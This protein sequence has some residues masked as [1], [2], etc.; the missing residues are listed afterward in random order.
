M[1]GILSIVPDI[2]SNFGINIPSSFTLTPPTGTFTARSTFTT[3]QAKT[4]NYN[5]LAHLTEIYLDNSGSLDAN[6]GEK[7][8]IN[9]AGVLNLSIQASLTDWITQ[10]SLSFLYFPEDVEP[11]QYQSSGQA[12]S[13]IINGAAANSN[14]IKSYQF[15]GDGY[16]L[17]R[18]HMVPKSTDLTPGAQGIY[19]DQTD[20]KWSLSYAFSVYDIEDVVDVPNLPKNLPLKCL[21]IYFRDFRAHILSNINIEYST[22][23][24][25][26]FQPNFASELDNQ[27]TLKTGEAMIDVLNIALA[28]PQTGGSYEFQQSLDENWDVGNSELF[29]TAPTEYSAMDN[30]NYLLNHHVS[31]KTLPSNN[32]T[33]LNDLCFLHTIRNGSYFGAIEKLALTPITDFFDKAGSGSNS[34]GELQLEHFF[35]TKTTEEG[36]TV[37]EYKAP[38][39]GNGKDVDLKTFKYG[40]IMQYSFVDMSPEINSSIFCTTPVYSVNIKDRRFS[41]RFQNNDVLTARR[42]I[43]DSY[44]SKLYKRGTNNENLFLPSIHQTKQGFNVTPRYS[45][46]GDNL[47]VLQKN[48]IHNLIYTGLLQNACICFKTLG[49]TLRQPGTFIAI[50]EANG[51]KDNDFSNKLYGQWFVVKVEHVFEAGAYVNNIYAIKVHRFKDA[52]TEFPQTI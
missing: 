39:G 21:K 12:Q 18:V 25:V 32:V 50:D 26:E 3:G 10:G 4:Q 17:L 38:L 22:A 48:G 20:P 42:V 51:S 16:D 40:Q 15:R 45:L 24:S 28:N 30:L 47:V 31:T 52:T 37:L 29:Y 34:P 6:V 19:I 1:A 14:I 5:D 23:Q 11:Q 2:L 46:N 8:F 43:A 36:S 49:L 41:T 7:F 13:T 35:V 9:P 44:I 27:G 33:Q